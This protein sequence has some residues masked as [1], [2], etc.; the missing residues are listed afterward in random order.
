MIS[1]IYQQASTVFLLNI[2]IS[3]PTPT[4]TASGNSLNS[5]AGSNNLGMTYPAPNGKWP[6]IY[7]AEPMV[8]E[9]W[10]KYNVS[11][12][13]DTYPGG[14][15]L[16]VADLTRQN[17]IYN[18]DCRVFQGCHIGQIGLPVPGP[19]Y[20]PLLSLENYSKFQASTIKAAGF[21]ANMVQSQALVI[22]EY[23]YL[24]IVSFEHPTEI[25][26][27]GFVILAISSQLAIDLYKYG[28]NG[29]KKWFQVAKIFN[30]LLAV[31]ASVAAVTMLVVTAGSGAV[32]SSMLVAGAVSLVVA[33]SN[34]AG[35]RA[36]DA[37]K[38]DAFS[39]WAD[40]TTMVGQWQEWTTKNANDQLDAILKAGIGTPEGLLGR[41]QDGQFLFDRQPQS[42]VEIEQRMTEIMTARLINHILN[43]IPSNCWGGGP[44]GALRLEDG[45]LSHC[46]KDG[47]MRNIIGAG[48]GSKAINNLYNAGAIVTKYKI[49]VEYM[50]QQSIDCQNKYGIGHDPYDNGYLWFFGGA[51]TSGMFHWVWILSVFSI[52][53]YAMLQ[54]TMALIFTAFSTHGMSLLN[55]TWARQLLEQRLAVPCEDP[56]S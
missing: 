19:L 14:K 11:G 12:Y 40:Y 13:L 47:V 56:L 52:Y 9:I 16:N 4:H 10:K 1:S 45:W 2:L 35:Q 29:A 6:N 15:E 43:M 3:Y 31:T 49:S 28:D 5:P 41:F 25:D 54:Q 32:L 33:G 20:Y 37:R 23:I 36:L 34:I 22:S 39:R 21:A 44:D 55:G 42:T 46:T 51:G 24:S 26:V 18:F 30:I 17:S 50:V 38:S 48:P 7:T 53:Q 27:D 8:P